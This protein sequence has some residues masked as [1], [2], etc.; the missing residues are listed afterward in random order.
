MSTLPVSKN[1]EAAVVALIWNMGAHSLCPDHYE[2]LE[3][4]LKQ[5]C[6]TRSISYEAVGL[7][8][9]VLSGKKSHSSDCS[10]FN[11]PAYLPGP[12]DC[13]EEQV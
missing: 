3:V 6:E 8:H 7:E 4:I 5:L 13:S 1:T 2:S 9:E 11:S 10:M 12:C